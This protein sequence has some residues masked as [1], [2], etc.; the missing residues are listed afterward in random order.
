MLHQAVEALV[1]Q[2]R[3]N[4][5]FVLSRHLNIRLMPRNTPSGMWGIFVWHDERAFLGF[6]KAAPLPR[7]QEFVAHGIGHYV[8]HRHHETLFI[9]MENPD[10]CPVEQEAQA[11]A[12]LLLK[13]ARGTA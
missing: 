6:D 2:Y 1:R 11:F 7:Q 8:L 12:N 5:P 13:G 10:G 9:E 3:T 4:N